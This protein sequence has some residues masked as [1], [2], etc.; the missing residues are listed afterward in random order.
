[1]G[2]YADDDD[3]EEEEAFGS[4]NHN[5]TFTTLKGRPPMCILHLLVYSLVT[6]WD[7]Q[8]PNFMGGGGSA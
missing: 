2:A 6:L 7:L 8:A 5:I 3:E 4:A 1:M